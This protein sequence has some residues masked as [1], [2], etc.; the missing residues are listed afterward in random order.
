MMKLEDI[1]HNP[2]QQPLNEIDNCIFSLL[3][4]AFSH[5]IISEIRM[6]DYDGGGMMA[7]IAII[8]ANIY[9]QLNAIKCQVLFP[10]LD[11]Y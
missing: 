8:I 3:K 6:C 5:F 11:L 7:M 10:V 4:S 2:F 1:L 9:L